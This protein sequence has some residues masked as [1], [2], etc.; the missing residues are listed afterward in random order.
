GS[1]FVSSGRVTVGHPVDVGSGAVFTL[2]IDFVIPGSLELRWRR[3]YS[4]VATGDMWLGPRW[5]VPYFMTLERRSEGYV[6]SGAHGEEVTFASPTG[7]LRPDAVL[8]NLGANMELHRD[9]RQ[10]L[11]LHWHDHGDVNRFSFPAADDGRVPLT[12]IENLAGH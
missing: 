2:S 9:G 5:T 11:V 8:L 4:T 6:L 1:R 10:F 7:P 3:H 12:C